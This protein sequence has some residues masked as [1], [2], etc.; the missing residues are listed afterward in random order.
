MKLTSLLSAETDLLRLEATLDR[1]RSGWGTDFI[2]EIQLAHEEILGQ[3]YRYPLVEDA[4]EYVREVHEYYIARFEIRVIYAIR[5]DEIIIV[6]YVHARQQ[7]G[8]WQD[9][10]FRPW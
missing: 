9:A 8:S 1:F 2:T 5:E 3:P 7:P 4:E 6:A 10:I